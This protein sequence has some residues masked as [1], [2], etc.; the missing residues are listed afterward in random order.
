MATINQYRFWNE[1]KQ[2]IEWEKERSENMNWS[3]QKSFCINRDHERKKSCWKCMAIA[4]AK[5]GHN[6]ASPDTI[7]VQYEFMNA[8]MWINALNAQIFFKKWFRQTLYIQMIMA[9]NCFPLKNWIQSGKR[10][11]SKIYY[12]K[13]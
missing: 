7:N 3:L 1:R 11:S 2:R 4:I 9:N 5:E 8:C 6:F 12:S 13:H 10:K